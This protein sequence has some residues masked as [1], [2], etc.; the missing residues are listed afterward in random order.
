VGVGTGAGA[1]PAAE[2]ATGEL[3]SGAEV[4]GG[5]GAVAFDFEVRVDFEGGGS[6]ISVT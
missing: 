6:V 4:G 3:R 1:P 2:A 5:G